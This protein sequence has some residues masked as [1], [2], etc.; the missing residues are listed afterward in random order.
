MTAALAAALTSA[1]SV[2][3]VAVDVEADN[4]VLAQDPIFPLELN[5]QLF[6][7]DVPDLRTSHTGYG[8]PRRGKKG[9]VRRW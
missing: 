8:P 4:T 9:K 2:T 6:I 3:L 5:D 7:T 1:A